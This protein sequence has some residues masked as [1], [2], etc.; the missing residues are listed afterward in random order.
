MRL[1]RSFI[2]CGILVT[3]VVAVHYWRRAT[4]EVYHTFTSP[5]GRFKVV[6]YRIPSVVAA[7]GDSGGARGYVRLYDSQTGRV[8]AQKNVEMVQSIDQMEWLSTNVDIKLFADWRL[9]K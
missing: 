9:P 3:L 8:L 6:V 7:P 1:R 2:I 4:A 5:D